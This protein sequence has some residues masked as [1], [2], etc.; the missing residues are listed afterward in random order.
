MLTR[1]IHRLTGSARPTPRRLAARVAAI[2]ESLD[3]RVLPAG[4][5]AAVVQNGSLTLQGDAENNT[6]E[7]TVTADG[8]IVHGHDGTTI[9]GAADFIAFAGA[10]AI[11]GDLVIHFAQGEDVALVS[12]EL[13]IGGNLRCRGGKGN[14]R[15]GLDHVTVGGDLV[16]VDR[17]GDAGVDIDQS[18]ITG[19]TRLRTSQGN[20]TLL[21]ADSM[22]GGALRVKTRD[23]SDA[24]HLDSVDI[25]GDASFRL[26]QSDNGLF[27]EDS[28]LE[29]DLL[30][31]TG[32][33]ADFVMF[34]AGSFAG[35]TNLRE[36]GGNDALV[37]TGPASFNGA[38]HAFG[39]RGDDA[40]DIADT[41]QFDDEPVLRRYE[42]DDVTAPVIFDRL[43]NAQTG[44]RTRSNALHEFFAAL[45]NM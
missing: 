27:V 43:D 30:V 17:R 9:N 3:C 29:G 39:A 28:Q 22:L 19:D 34:E 2:V 4:N 42:L 15:I 38:F 13:S 37:V 11:P 33:G 45:L 21:I 18:T 23:G 6:I 5:I 31:R 10:D 25:A 1:L 32:M 35:A 14:D 20:T 44:I 26:G 7:V 41:A 24:V 36:R 8:V 16:V 12:G 40:A